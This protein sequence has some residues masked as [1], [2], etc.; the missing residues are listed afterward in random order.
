M[1]PLLLLLACS[2]LKDSGSTA[3]DGGLGD[4]GSADGGSGDG[5][6][7]TTSGDGGGS[8]TGDGG[9]TTT[10]G[11]GSEDL[12]LPDFALVDL[13]PNSPLYGRS[14]SPRDY[15]EQVSGWYFTHAS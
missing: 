4:G 10:D 6:G 8:T 7:S 3:G 13:N 2:P 14:I 11:G 15:L 5:G 9:G 12:A 1:I